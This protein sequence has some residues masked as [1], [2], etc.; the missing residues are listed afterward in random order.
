MGNQIS[1]LCYPALAPCRGGM[2][3]MYRTCNYGFSHPTELG[4]CLHE[5]EDLSRVYDT[6]TRCSHLVSGMR[7]LLTGMDRDLFRWLT[8]NT[9]SIA[10]CR[11]LYRMN[12]L[13]H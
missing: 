11:I 12:P 6:R 4:G 5:I 8:L 2:L 3:D 9:C 1:D 13:N 10:Y 7:I